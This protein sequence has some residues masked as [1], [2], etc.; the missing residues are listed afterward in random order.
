MP[1]R[2]SNTFG[3]VPLVAYNFRYSIVESN[4]DVN[5]VNDTQAPGNSMYYGTDGSGSKGWHVL[6]AAGIPDAPADGV[7]YGREDNT[8][9]SIDSVFATDSALAAHTGATDNPHSVTLAQLGGASEADLN[10]HIADNANP[11]GVTAAQV[12]SPTT[13]EFTTLETA[14]N[15]HEADTSNPHGVTAAQVDAPTTADFAAHTGDSSNPHS[16]TAAQVGLSST[17]DLAEGSTNLYYTEPRVSANSDVSANTSARHTHSN[18]TVL[19]A[20]PDT[21]G[22]DGQFLRVDNLG[23]IEWTD[24]SPGGVAGSGVEDHIAVWTST[25][26]ISNAQL[27]SIIGGP[28]GGIFQIGSDNTDSYS[29]YYNTMFPYLDF[30][31][32]NAPTVHILQLFEDGNVAIPNIPTQVRTDTLYYNASDG[33]LWYGA[34]NAIVT[35]SPEFQQAQADIVD[36][37]QR[38][39]AA[40]L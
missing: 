37:K 7:M 3:P 11:H 31:F 5:L 32:T 18:S 28:T 36:I 25:G 19:N 26:E 4:G 39:T 1:T 23:G 20:I 13:A 6:D 12:G 34:A 27:K 29:I 21:M 35:N 8:W 33:T 38:L 16:V 17:D 24:V 10:A 2:T 14:F 22:A 15:T 40:G 9:V 30:Y